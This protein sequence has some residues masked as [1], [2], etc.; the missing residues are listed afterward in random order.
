MV[1]PIKYTL[2]HINLTP[3]IC[4]NSLL[5]AEGN[6]TNCKR[7]IFPHQHRLKDEIVEL[8]FSANQARQS[9]S[10]AENEIKH[11]KLSLMHCKERY[12]FDLK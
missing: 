3:N 10:Q 4:D 11:K 1:N 9:K 8:D 6:V 2:N 12:K 5:L 7:D